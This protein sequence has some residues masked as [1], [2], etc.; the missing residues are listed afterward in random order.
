M[1]TFSAV[2]DFRGTAI[3]YNVSKHIKVNTYLLALDIVGNSPMVL[4]SQPANGTW[5]IPRC[6]GLVLTLFGKNCT[7]SL[8]VLKC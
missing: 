5:R 1:V 7:H 3:K 6:I 2:L 4:T 8:Q